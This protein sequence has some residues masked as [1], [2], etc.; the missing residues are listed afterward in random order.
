MAK[1]TRAHLALPRSIVYRD[2]AVVHTDGKQGR[3]SLGKVETSDAAVGTDRTLRVLG[4]ADLIK[5]A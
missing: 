4:V 3:V 2:G 5:R 1:G